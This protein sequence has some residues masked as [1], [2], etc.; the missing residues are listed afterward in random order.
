[1][2]SKIVDAAGNLSAAARVSLCMTTAIHT[3]D[4]HSPD[5]LTA[6]PAALGTAAAKIDRV[7]DRLTV[8][9]TEVPALFPVPL[10]QAE[11]LREALSRAR[12]RQQDALAG[13]VTFYRE[14]SRSLDATTRGIRG[15]ED[16]SAASFGQASGQ[17][18]PS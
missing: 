1:M 15:T 10:P 13:C 17:G 11:S 2:P 9:G 8:T 6:D 3:T 18:E 5:S 16:A 7:A 14:S 4:G 12:A